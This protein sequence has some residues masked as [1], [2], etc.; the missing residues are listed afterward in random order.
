MPAKKKYQI[1]RSFCCEVDGKDIYYPKFVKNTV[2][3]TG[4]TEKQPNITTLPADAIKF[5]KKINAIKALS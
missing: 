4:Q 3:E 1:L 2:D 5:G